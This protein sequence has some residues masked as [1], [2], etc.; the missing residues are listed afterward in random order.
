MFSTPHPEPTARSCSIAGA[1]HDHAGG[2]LAAFRQD[3]YDSLTRRADGLFELCDAVLCSDGP[4]T[5]LVGVSLTPEHR[6][7]HGGH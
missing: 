2:D 7:G 5:T 3:L 1:G 6:R 4:V